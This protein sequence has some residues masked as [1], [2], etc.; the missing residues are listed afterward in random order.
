MPISSGSSR[1]PRRISSRSRRFDAAEATAR[2]ADAALAAAQAALLGADARVGAARAARDQAALNLSYTR[3]TAPAEGVVSKK[4]VEVGQLVQPGQPLMSLVAV[5][6]RVGDGEPERD[7]D[8]GREPGDPADFTVDA[9]PG[10][11]FSGHVESLSPRPGRSSRCCARQTRR[12]T[13]PRSYSGSRCGSGSTGRTT[14]RIR[15]GRDERER[16]HHDEV[17]DRVATAAL[18]VPSSAPTPTG[19]S[20]ATSSRSRCRSRRCS[21]CSTPAS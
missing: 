18:R 20:T 8:G 12:E 11:H 5:G 14:P 2:A 4:S 17:G 9:Y 16:D 3:I 19:T 15:S 7:A 21:S 6:R 13:S 1:S 10:R